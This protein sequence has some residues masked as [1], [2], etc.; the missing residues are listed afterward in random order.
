MGNIKM[1]EGHHTITPY[2]VVEGVDKQIEFL[3]QVFNAQERLKIPKSEGVVAHAEVNIGD[4]V[5][6]MA[7]ATEQFKITNGMLYVYVENTDE[8]YKRAL[9]AGATSIM[10]PFDEAYGARSAG[11]KDPFGNQWWFATLK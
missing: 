3:K 9:D 8:S 1:A 4:S 5:V 6:M 2:L 7:D 11:V 10:E